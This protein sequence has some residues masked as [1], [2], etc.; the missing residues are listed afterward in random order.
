[1]T[2]SKAGQQTEHVG[3]VAFGFIRF[4]SS[5]GAVIVVVA[6]EDDENIPS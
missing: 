6:G 1:M 2:M 5:I 3:A 4:R